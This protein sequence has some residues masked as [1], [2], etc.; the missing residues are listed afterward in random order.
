MRGV[1]WLALAIGLASAI[2]AGFWIEREVEQKAR[3]DVASRAKDFADELESRPAP[4]SGSV[5]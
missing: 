2:G 5:T 3:A 1:P 4:L